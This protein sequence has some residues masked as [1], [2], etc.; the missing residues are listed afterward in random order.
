[1]QVYTLSWSV[2]E[3]RIVLYISSLCVN[4]KIDEGPPKS[5]KC[6]ACLQATELSINSH[7]IKNIT[8]YPHEPNS[9]VFVSIVFLVTI[10][11]KCI[12]YFG[13]SITQP[14]HLP[15]GLSNY[16]YKSQRH[17]FACSMAC[18]FKVEWLY[19]IELQLWEIHFSV[20]LTKVSINC[21]KLIFKETFTRKQCNFHHVLNSC[22][23]YSISS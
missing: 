8:K 2:N 21:I 22:F 10:I 23:L 9:E 16:I 11:L 3:Q 17:Q 6:Q 13:T 5:P 15:N 14:W 19:L 7:Q 4:N 20:L 12:K 18:K 1:M